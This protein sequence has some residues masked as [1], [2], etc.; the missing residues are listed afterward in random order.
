MASETPVAMFGIQK[1]KIE[2]G[3]A[4]EFIVCSEENELLDTL[5]Y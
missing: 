3:Y 1:G 4:A 5:I 2:L